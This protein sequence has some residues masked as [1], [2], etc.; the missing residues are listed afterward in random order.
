MIVVFISI[1]FG[2][3]TT[4]MVFVHLNLSSLV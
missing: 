1:G 3:C 2:T 4:I